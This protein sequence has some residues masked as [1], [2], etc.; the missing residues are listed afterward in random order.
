M[1]STHGVPNQESKINCAWPIA[2][3]IA[4]GPPYDTQPTGFAE[5]ISDGGDEARQLKQL[6]RRS[7]L[8]EKSRQRALA[9][10]RYRS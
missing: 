1:A 5:V 4:S 9:L 3:L 8:R 7:M 6:G 2:L 10:F